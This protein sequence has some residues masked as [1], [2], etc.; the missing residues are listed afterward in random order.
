M[1]ANRNALSEQEEAVIVAVDALTLLNELPAPGRIGLQA[2]PPMTT[3]EVMLTAGK[4]A[5][6]GLLNVHDNEGVTAYLLTPEGFEWAN[7]ITARGT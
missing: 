6:A 2:D 3:S 4:L 1:Q 5:G 7:A